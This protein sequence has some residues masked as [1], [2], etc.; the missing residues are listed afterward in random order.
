SLGEHPLGGLHPGDVTLNRFDSER[1]VGLV[2]G[3]LEAEVEELGLQLGQLLVQIGRAHLGQFVRFHY[4]ADSSTSLFTNLHLMGSLWAARRMASRAFSSETPSISNSTR[5]GL[6]TA[7]QYSGL[8]LPEPMRV[9]AGF[10]VTGLSG[11][12]LIQTLPPRLV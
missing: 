10:S 1:V 9:S 7:T 6:T 11:K 12:I 3:V 4:S 2:D 5:P 8:P